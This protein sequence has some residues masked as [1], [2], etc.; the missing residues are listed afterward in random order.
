MNLWNCL[1]IRIITTIFL[2][3]MTTFWFHESIL[4]AIGD[5]LIIQDDLHAA[6]LIHVISGPDHRTDYGIYLMKQG[7]GKTIF[8]TGGWCPDIQGIHAERGEDRA[9]TQGIQPQAIAIDGFQV[10]STYAEVVRLKEFIDSMAIPVES[11]IVVSDPYHMRRSHWV[12]QRVLGKEIDL[13]MAPVP[14]ELSPYD[15]DWW[16]HKK[17]RKMVGDEYL[18]TLYYYTRYQFSWGPI[19]DWLASFDQY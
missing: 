13:I 16:H 14:F 6:D 3:S 12:Y 5:F 10:T 9:V 19:S 1:L 8:F 4:L 7:Y 11:L 17:S 2:L 15:R 18:K